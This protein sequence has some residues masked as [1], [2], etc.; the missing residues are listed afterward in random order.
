M[1]KGK[2]RDLQRGHQER[3]KGE[4]LTIPSLWKGK[5]GGPTL[6]GSGEERLTDLVHGSWK[7][8]PGRSGALSFKS[9]EET[10]MHNAS[11]PTH[12][13]RK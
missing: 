5:R 9:W 8:R 12:T 10:E 6:R 13:Q 11:I 2:S 3:G 7:A 4:D 1:N